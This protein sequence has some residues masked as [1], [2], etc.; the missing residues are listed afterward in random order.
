MANPGVGTFPPAAIEW[1]APADPATVLAVGLGSLPTAARFARRG[2]R[3]TVID[4]PADALGR[5]TTRYPDMLAVAAAPESLP[6]AAHSFDQILVA[7][8]LHLLAPGLALAEFAR[9]LAPGGSLAVLYTVRDDSVPWVRRLATLLQTYDPQLMSGAPATDAIQA[10]GYFPNVHRRDFRQWVP[11]NADGLI[12]LVSRNP[13]LAQLPEP[14]ASDLLAKVA[15]LYEA[16]AKAP[17][18][19]LLPY[20]VRCWRARVDHSE[21]T[22]AFAAP[23]PGLQITL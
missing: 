10:S 20:S 19:L 9:V 1:L 11:I 6:F 14:D 12:E 22:T 23:E 17:E 15:A 2:H 13:R 18:P 7:Q 5:A 16:S 4:R 3:I 8:G 21:F